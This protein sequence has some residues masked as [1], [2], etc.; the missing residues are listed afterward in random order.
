MSDLMSRRALWCSA[1]KELRNAA[2][3]VH[4]VALF[5]CNVTSSSFIHEPFSQCTLTDVIDDA[6]QVNRKICAYNERTK[7]HMGRQISSRYA[8]AQSTDMIRQPAPA[9]TRAS[10]SSQTSPSHDALLQT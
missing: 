5:Y 8:R 9:A 4:L 6:L 1:E 2:T 10:F 7:G 3:G